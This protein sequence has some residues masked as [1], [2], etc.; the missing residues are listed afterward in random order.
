[1][2]KNYLISGKF[3]Y[4]NEEFR[5]APYETLEQFLLEVMDVRIVRKED[6]C[7][8]IIN[9]GYDYKD[10]FSNEEEIRRFEDNDNFIMF[11]GLE[12]YYT[13]ADSDIDKTIID[14]IKENKEFRRTFKELIINDK[15]VI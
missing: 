3:N 10:W 7:K 12:P 8:N 11:D 14:Y 6:I 4:E 2:N 13:L 5:N 15:R 1:M 9:L